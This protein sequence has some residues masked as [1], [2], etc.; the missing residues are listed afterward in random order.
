MG[1]C[2]A[3]L[4]GSSSS[5]SP[6]RIFPL[7]P[8]PL[9][10]SFGRFKGWFNCLSQSLSLDTQIFQQLDGRSC[11][12]TSAFHLNWIDS[13]IPPA[14][15]CVCSQFCIAQLLA[16]VGL[17]CW[18]L[19]WDCYFYDI[20]GLTREGPEYHVWSEVSCCNG[21]T[22]MTHWMAH[23]LIADQCPPSCSN[24]G[25]WLAFQLLVWLRG[26]WAFLVSLEQKLGWSCA[27]SWKRSWWCASWS[28]ERLPDFWGPGCA[29]RCTVPA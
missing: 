11:H 9:A 7:C 26:G 6:A 5:L 25:P 23:W 22:N 17:L 3:L 20:D 14:L 19:P 16:F 10:A 4:G 13:C 29:S 12:K 8:D 24:P 15:L 2:G 28:L 1:K 18:T 27:L 21:P